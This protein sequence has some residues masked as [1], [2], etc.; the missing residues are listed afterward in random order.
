MTYM[1]TPKIKKEFQEMMYQIAVYNS[2]EA[3][4][5]NDDETKKATKERKKTLS[6]FKLKGA[7]PRRMDRT[8]LRK[9]WVAGSSPAGGTRLIIRFPK[10]KTNFIAQIIGRAMDPLIHHRSRKSL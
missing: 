8:S 3:E 4:K 7:S 10:S 9:A 2:K 6:K 1:K 5:T